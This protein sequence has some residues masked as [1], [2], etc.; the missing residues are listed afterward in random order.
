[1]PYLSAQHAAYLAKQMREFRDGARP[2]RPKERMR[3]T[4]RPLSDTQIAA[5]AAYLA[6][7]ERSSTP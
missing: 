7:R 1:M 5:I 6:S 4:L 2:D 3:E